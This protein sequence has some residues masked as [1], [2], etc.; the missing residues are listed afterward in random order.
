MKQTRN[1]LKSLG[2]SE[3][4]GDLCFVIGESFRCGYGVM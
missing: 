1:Y 2:D 4:M 3:R